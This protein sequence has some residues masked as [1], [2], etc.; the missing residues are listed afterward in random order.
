MIQSLIGL[1]LSYNLICLF[2]DLFYFNFFKKGIIT[3]LLSTLGGISSS[4]G[5]CGVGCR[6][7]IETY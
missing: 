1:L 5:G 6:C 7:Y 4:G 2:S 3:N